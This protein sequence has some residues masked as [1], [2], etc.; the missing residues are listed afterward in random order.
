MKRLYFHG[1]TFVPSRWYIHPVKADQP[2]IKFGAIKINSENKKIGSD[3][4]N[5]KH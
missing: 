5:L 1:G 4:P 2:K 3:T